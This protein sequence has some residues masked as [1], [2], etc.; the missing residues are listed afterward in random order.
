MNHIPD[1]IKN[2]R[3]DLDRVEERLVEK[4]VNRALDAVDGVRAGV[5]A[6]HL[7]VWREHHI[8][9]TGAKKHGT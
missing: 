2:I 4:D 1:I 3:A 9:G 5:Q 8:S 6:L 7:A